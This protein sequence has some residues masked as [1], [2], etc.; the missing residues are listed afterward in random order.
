MDSSEI[1]F[2]VHL[3]RA[4]SA[5]H[6]GFLRVYRSRDTNSRRIIDQ[7][8]S[9]HGRLDRRAIDHEATCRVV[10]TRKQGRL[11]PLEVAYNDGQ[12]SSQIR[13]AGGRMQAQGSA[14]S[15]NNDAVPDD[16]MP[17][18]AVFA[19]ASAIYNQPEAS[20]TFTP[21]TEGSGHLGT[22]AKLLC[23]GRTGTTPFPTA[24]PLWEVIWLNAEGTRVQ[25]FYFDDKGELAQADWGSSRAVRVATEVQARPAPKPS[26]SGRQKKVTP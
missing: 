23:C 15:E 5:S 22:G 13:F 7:Q 10:L 16:V 3:G 25:A 9:I 19:L 2:A 11:V 6:A 20:L 12:Q 14:A 21:L 1:W 24:A 26:R 4:A 8:V 17:T 18:Y